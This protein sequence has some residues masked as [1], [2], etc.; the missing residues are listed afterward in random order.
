[1]TISFSSHCDTK[2]TWE[3][4]CMGIAGIKKW[5]NRV[6]GIHSFCYLFTGKSCGGP[7]FHLSERMTDTCKEKASRKIPGFR[8]KYTS[9]LLSP[10]YPK[11]TNI[12]KK[13]KVFAIIYA[14]DAF[15]SPLHWKWKT[16]PDCKTPSLLRSHVTSWQAGWSAM[17]TAWVASKQLLT[18][19]SPRVNH[20]LSLPQP[21]GTWKGL[22]NLTRG[23][24]AAVVEG[25]RLSSGG[26]LSKGTQPS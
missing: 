17:L 6:S 1:M 7:H 13:D 19:H 8:Q 15:F 9:V 11:R 25:H 10:N 26:S 12:F 2:E 16:S 18:L 22:L 4:K 14:S 5:Q 21:F 24:D 23:P 3:P 20:G